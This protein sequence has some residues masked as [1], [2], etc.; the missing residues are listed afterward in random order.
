MKGIIGA[1]CGDIIGSTREFNRIKTKDFD[2]FEINSCFT[3]DTIMT[4]AIA[5]WLIRDKSSKKVLVEKLKYWGRKYPN[6]GYGGRFN[7]WLKQDSPQAYGSWANGSAMRVSP[8]AW[9]GDSLEE[10]QKL[11]Y[12]SAVVTHDDPEGIK[13]AL[14]TADAIYLARLGAKKE[15]IKDH[16]EV[17]YEYDLSR[18][19]D[20]I[21]PMVLAVESVFPLYLRHCGGQRNGS[22]VGGGLAEPGHGDAQ[23]AC[24]QADDQD[25]DQHPYG[26]ELAEDGA[27]LLL[28]GFAAHLLPPPFRYF[29]LTY[30]SRLPYSLT[31]ML[32]MPSRSITAMRMQMPWTMMSARLGCNPG[33][34]LRSSMGMSA[35]S[36]AMW[37]MKSFVS[38]VPCM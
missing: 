7:E 6:S 25:G 26:Q 5:D 10:V 14:A 28:A 27:A 33:R 13:G 31:V 11:A 30:P 19:V 17:R 18:K 34:S 3:D 16:I 23:D 1:I 38:T 32:L 21:R 2:L 29:H 35:R 4:L 36:R 22:L 20:D 8:C 12:D 24:P 37:V 9:V 15:E